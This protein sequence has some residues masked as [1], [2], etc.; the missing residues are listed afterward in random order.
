[1]ARFGDF[2]QYLDNAGDPLAEGKL[3][4]YESGTTTPKTTYSDVNNSIPNT[5]PVL[6]SAA[7]R[8][9]NIFFDGVAKVILT[10]NDDV[11]LIVRDPVGE[12]ATDFGDQWVSTKIYNATDVVLGSDGTYYR[13]LINGNQN[14]NPVTTTGNWTLLYSVEWN[15]GITY[16]VGAVVTY[17][18][19]QYQSLQGSN[20]NQNPSSASSYWVLLSFAWLATATYSEDQNAVGTDGILYTSLQNS[21]TGNDPASS[22]AYWVGT[23][24]AA[25]ASAVAAAASAAAALVSENAAAAD[26]IA[27]AADVVQTGLDAAATAADAIATAADRVQTGLDAAATAADVILTNADA[28][29]TAADR[30]QTGL[31]AAATSADAIATAADRVQTGLDVI[32]T[33]ADAIATAADA[34]ATA[35]DVVQT[36]LDV[37]ATSADV[38]QTG[39]DVTAAAGS[40]SAASG[41]AS[42]AAGSAAAAAA[43]YDAFDDRY[44]GDKASDPT[45]D[46]DGN[47]LLTGALYFNTTSDVMKVYDGSAWNIAAISSASPTFTGTVTAD[48]L[49][50]GDN[51]KAT[52][53]A[54]NDL[55]IYSDGANAII[56]HTNTGAGALFIKGDNNVIITNQAGTENKAVFASNGAVTAY[57]DNAAKLAT[58]NTGIDVTGTA[59]MDGL[60]VDGNAVIS[61]SSFD[62]LYLRRTSTGSTTLVM[63]NSV[64]N[65]GALQADSNGLRLYTRTSSSFDQRINLANNGD[66]SFYEDTGTTPKFFWDASAESLGIG[67]TSPDSTAQ[68]HTLTTSATAR[69]I[70]ESTSASGYSG[71]R[72]KN[73][74]G[75]WEMQIDGAN[76]GLR[77]LDDGT[78]RLRIDSS[79]NVGIGTSSPFPFS[80]AQ[81]GLTL[82]G[83]SGSFPT[84]AGALSFISQ[85]TTST[86][87]HIH[88]RDAYMAFETGTSAT[89]TERMRIDA[90]GNVGIGTSSPSVALEIHDASANVTIRD[91]STAATGVGGIL[92]FQGYT[93]GT[94][95]ANNFA[96][97]KG[98]KANGTVGGEFV[99]RTSD[100]AGSLQERLRIN[101]NGNVGIGTTSPTTFS[102]FLTV[103][104]KNSSGDAIHL[105]ESDGGIIAQTIANDASG[106]VTT[107]SRSNHP[108]RV[109]TNDIERLRIDSSGN[110][111]IGT[112]SPTAFGGGFIVSETSGSSG[113]YSLQSS[114]AVVTQIAADSTASVGYTGT[115]SNHPYVFT[116]NNAER[117]RIDSSGNVGIG[118]T[119]VSTLHLKAASGNTGLILQDAAGSPYISWLDTAGTIQWQ[120]YSTMNGVA[121]LDPLVFY[122]SAGERMRIDSGG[123]VGIGTSS[124]ASLASLSK[125]GGE[126]I[127]ELNRANSNTAGALG[128]I[129]WTASDGHS[130][131]NIYAQGDGD[132]EG[133]HLVFRTTSAAGEND[134]YGANTTERMRIDASGNVLFGVTSLTNNGS[135][136]KS[137]A[138]DLM[139]LNIGST[140]TTTQNV[141]VFRNPNAAVGTISTNASATAYNTSS[142]QRLKENIA[143]AEDAGSKVDAIQVRQ[144]DWKVDGSHQDYGMVAQELM[145]V[146]PEAVTQPENP[147]DMM[148]VDYSKLVPMLIK[149]IQSLRN[150]VATLEGN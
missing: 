63:E 115:R 57:Y 95:G 149:E 4:F 136:F 22:P 6:L 13:S 83:T 109:T 74:S 21:N 108:W 103:H 45:L 127:L 28:V 122:S 72:L 146:A 87:C 47:A 131:A 81:A 68:L 139:Q 86:E 37:V 55:E 67:T 84:R 35:A 25:A 110:V 80:S 53:G 9:P 31:D 126:A 70:I 145:T 17:D 42:A 66:I 130:V 56:D 128:A 61:S 62:P 141:V 34:I 114:G 138:S 51:D 73:A 39:L 19:E 60:T 148:G 79:G 41:S 111:G 88:A 147:E 52:F 94:S 140:T 54:G 119:P 48:G 99:V 30:V 18:G 49:S 69:N 106:V 7:G 76:Q 117:M 36:G 92:R 133:A 105:V 3:Y 144:F 112:S 59:T 50:L 12:T 100:T 15:A 143:D 75:Y 118:T 64:N 142:D 125:T 27:T 113:G 90:S 14:N 8:Q 33:N 38:V 134:P 93:S 85:D 102:G 135:Y 1:M 32:A 43:S 104:Q 107:G 77:W 26:A 98:V 137:S 150:R 24:A 123:R 129:N 29:A 65:G 58:T 96:E 10:D 20:L 116:T 101:S 71:N 121:G 5:N 120:I 46:N 91:T 82:S 40:A 2:D 132:N 44:L 11:Q 16:Q 78:E 124:P 23:S 89:S 97:V